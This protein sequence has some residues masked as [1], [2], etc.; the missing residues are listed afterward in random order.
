MMLTVSV[1]H[2][3]SSIPAT[4]YRDSIVLIRPPNAIPN[5]SKRV[6]LLY[7]ILVKWWLG[8]TG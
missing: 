1:Y 5:A 3:G 2:N 7:N 4:G 8:A 6:I